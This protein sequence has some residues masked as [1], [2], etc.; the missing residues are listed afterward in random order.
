MAAIDPRVDQADARNFIS[1]VGE[2]GSLKQLV[3][4]ILLLFRPQG[5]KELGL[6]PW[7]VQAPL[8]Y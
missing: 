3:E 4:P 5:I 6:F 8:C 2:L 1:D 7:L